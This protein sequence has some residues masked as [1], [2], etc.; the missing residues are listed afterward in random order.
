DFNASDGIAAGRYDFFG[1]AEHEITETMGRSLEVGGRIGGV[2]SYLPLDLFHFSSAGVHD[3]VGTKA[4]YFSI[5]NGHTK[6]ANFNTDP[7]GDFG[8]WSSAFKK[9]VDAFAAFSL[10][11]VVNP[12]SEVDLKV[13]NVLGYQRASPSA[14]PADALVASLSDGHH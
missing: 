5:D 3:F 11:G 7:T 8:D 10:T 9:G 4:G 14:A 2:R 6:L 1:A 12:V 13:M